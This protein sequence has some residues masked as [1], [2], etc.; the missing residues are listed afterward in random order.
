MLLA[1]AGCGGGPEEN[2]KSTADRPADTINGTRD[3]ALENGDSDH[4]KDPVL[5][6]DFYTMNTTL[7]LAGQFKELGYNFMGQ[8]VD[9]YFQ[10]KD[11]V[12]GV[13][14]EYV[15]IK[16]DNTV[17]DVW[18]GSDGE[19]IKAVADGQEFP[20]EQAQLVQH[21]FGLLEVLVDEQ[22]WDRRWVDGEQTRDTRDLGAGPVDIT[23]YKWT[24]PLM[25]TYI[26]IEVAEI[27][28]RN[29]I[30]K[31]WQYT[32]DDTSISGWELYRVIPR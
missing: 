20:P 3:E 4:D 17:L 30:I 18:V 14:A 25:P 11:T 16:A 22:E 21:M 5:D 32:N 23:R 19:I 26:E 27:A 9:Y 13:Q 29:L 10:G 28:G 6:K 15:I 7:D 31:L 24:I 12:N 2:V 8:K 1:A